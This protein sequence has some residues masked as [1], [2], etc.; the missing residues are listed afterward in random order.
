[1]RSELETLA[2]LKER[3]HASIEKTAGVALVISLISGLLLVLAVLLCPNQSLAIQ[4]ARAGVGLAVSTAALIGLGLLSRCGGKAAIIFFSVCCYIGTTGLSI[5][6]GTG[7]ASP[8]N[9]AAL[10]LAVLSGF[11]VSPRTGILTTAVSLAGVFVMTAAQYL[12]WISGLNADNIP[13]ATTYLVSYVSMF[14]IAG[15]AIYQFGTMFWQAIAQ[16]DRD[17]VALEDKIIQQQRTKAKLKDSERRLTALLDT[18][19][20]AILIFQIE[21]GRLHY[22]NQHAMREHQVD[23]LRDLERLAVG[24]AEPY[25]H[26]DLL[27]AIEQTCELGP[28]E[29]QWRTVNKAGREL[30]WSVKLD[31]LAL[32]GVEYVAAFGENITD[33]I[34][35]H[36]SL[37]DEQ[38]RLEEKVKERTKELLE[39]QRQLNAILDALPVSLSIKD[40]QGRYQMC[41]HVFEDMV[42]KPKEHILG[43]TDGELFGFPTAFAIGHDD[44]H[45]IA[46]RECKRSEQ[47]IPS[48]QGDLKDYLVTKVPLLDSQGDAQGLLT[49]ATDISDIKALQR[50]LRAATKEAE[51]LAQIKAEF[52]ANMSHEIRTP[53]NG[54]LGLA[55]I[56]TREHAD[57]PSAHA[58]F[59][60]ITRSGQHLLGVIN[61]ILDFSKIDAGKMHIEANCIN[62]LQIAEDAMGVLAERAASKG[63]D[64]SLRA[65]A[66][67]QWIIGDSLRIQQILINL[68][69]NAVK[70]TEQGQVTLSVE[71]KNN[72]LTFAVTDSGIGMSAQMLSRVFSPF[73]QADTSITR[74][75]GGTG[76]GLTISRQLARLMG[77][78]IHVVSTPG[79]GST[80]SLELPNQVVPHLGLPP[81]SRHHPK[82]IG[83]SPLAGL[84]VLAVDDVDV[85]RE[86]LLSLLESE[87]AEA[88]TAVDGLDA[89][90]RIRRHTPDYF[91]LVLMDVQMPIMDGLAATI[92]LKQF[93]PGLPVIAL[94]AHALPEERARCIEAGMCSH[95]PKPVDPEKMVA[96]ILDKVR[97]HQTQ[98]P[99]TCSTAMPTPLESTPTTMHELP[100]LAGV[101][102][103]MALAR[104]GGKVHVLIKL[105]HTFSQNQHGLAPRLESQL[106]DTPDQAR[107]TAHAL[108]GT[109]ANL[110]FGELSGLAAKLEEACQQ[111]P[112]TAL[113]ILHQLEQKLDETLIRLDEWLA[114]ADESLRIAYNT[115]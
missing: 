2:G 99:T 93:A 61:D 27:L 110:G 89:L 36:Q 21:D 67:P 92:E 50:E 25:S 109:S 65:T 16:L 88:E 23:V 63:L 83:M 77:G 42:G 29:R 6:A 59:Q 57:T 17:R 86:I 87:G 35:V 34:T 11:L 58:L 49:L 20:M 44:A 56:G 81:A 30:W 40:V 114:R 106:S 32:D 13:P 24:T 85:N 107:R 71:Q 54:V 82:P 68:L 47:D 80:F 28:H 46:E 94:T 108:K 26:A 19:P 43:H 112:S 38:F 12:G 78:D 105:L 39:Q 52:L 91:D 95:L 41:N 7:V 53:L 70:F 51:R 10:T 45:V 55:H 79:K 103:N 1:M 111:G 104:C 22:A 64:L 4:H 3:V 113:P 97:L 33:Q 14:V 75:F 100:P 48:T 96:E 73:E 66:L 15:W 90:T 69:S 102:L 37:I 18:A 72:Q 60:K 8:G 101:D 9:A 5:Y 98:Q 31:L 115:P 84:R 62:P 74:Q 76:L